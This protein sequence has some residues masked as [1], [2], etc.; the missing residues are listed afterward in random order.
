M[1]WGQTTTFHNPPGHEPK[2]WVTLA[3]KH[4]RLACTHRNEVRETFTRGGP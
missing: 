2:A 4:G 1:L 3:I